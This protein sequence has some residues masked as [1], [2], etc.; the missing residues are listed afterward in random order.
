MEIDNWAIELDIG[1]SPNELF[2]AFVWTVI[3][4]K[5]HDTLMDPRRLHGF[6]TSARIKV[7][8]PSVDQMIHAR[9]TFASN[10]PGTEYGG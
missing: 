4:S 5:D 8:T 6:Q 2:G 3:E 9:N 1:K 10:I 7:G